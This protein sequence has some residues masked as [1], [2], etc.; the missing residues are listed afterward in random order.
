MPKKT[1]VTTIDSGLSAKRSAELNEVNKKKY[2]G[3]LNGGSL[4]IA[5]SRIIAEL[6]LQDLSKD[7]WDQQIVD[8][9]RLQKNS[10]QTASRNARTMRARLEPMGKPFIQALLQAPER[11]YVQ[12]LMVAFLIHSPVVADFMRQKLAEARRTYKPELAKNA[13]E[14][15][16]N[17]RIRAIPALEKYSPSTLGKMGRFAVQALIDCGY[18]NNKRERKIQPVYLLPEV[19]KWLTEL[20]KE[21]LIS[22]MECTL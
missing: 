14:E 10:V 6:L 3:D 4:W 18:L 19:K 12:M 15:F 1:S 21:E 16:M 7:E 17:D 22:V 13:W 20:K 5:E 8:E 9:N 11:A 2:I